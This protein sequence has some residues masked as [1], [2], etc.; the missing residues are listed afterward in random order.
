VIGGLFVPYDD[1]GLMVHGNK[2]FRLSKFGRWNLEFS[3]RMLGELDHISSLASK[4][5]FSMKAH[6]SKSLPGI[7]MFA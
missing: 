3:S 7:D 4:G 1:P 6:M 5:S 2:K